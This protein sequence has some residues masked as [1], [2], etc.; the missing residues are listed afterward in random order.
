MEIWKMMFLFNWAILK[1]P[2]LNFPVEYLF[3]VRDPLDLPPTPPR[4]KKNI[5][6]RESPLTEFSGG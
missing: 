5:F 3:S 2:A 4:K 6:G 1:V